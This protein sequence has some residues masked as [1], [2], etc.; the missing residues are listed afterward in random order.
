[1]LL[2]NLF[3]SMS[4]QTATS[5]NK[6]AVAAETDRFGTRAICRTNITFS[7]STSCCCVSNSLTLFHSHLSRVDSFFFPFLPYCI[8]CCKCVC[9]PDQE[10]F[11]PA[12]KQYLPTGR[13]V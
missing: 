1:M 4:Q 8:E 10:G 3:S 13:K 6:E 9:A 2:A 11:T 7:R 12:P 5:K